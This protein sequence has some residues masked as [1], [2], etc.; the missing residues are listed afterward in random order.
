MKRT[1]QILNSRPQINHAVASTALCVGLHDLEEQQNHDVLQCCNNKKLK[2]LY[3]EKNH[4]L[5]QLKFAALT[6]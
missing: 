4:T 1:K 3:Q 5:K 6:K 2:E